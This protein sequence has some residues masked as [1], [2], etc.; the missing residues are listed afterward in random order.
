MRE[1]YK[2]IGLWLICGSSVV[3]AT[4]QYYTMVSTYTE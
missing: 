2:E 1:L 3:L 4:W